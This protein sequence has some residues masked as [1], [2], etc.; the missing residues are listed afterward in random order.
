MLS[1]PASAADG[2]PLDESPNETAYFLSASLPEKDLVPLIQAA[3]KHNMPVYFRGLINNDMKTTANYIQYLVGKYHIAGI[4]ID[5]LRPGAGETL[6]GAVR[7]SVWQRCTQS[8]PGHHCAPRA[9]RRKQ[10]EA[11]MWR[12]TLS[13]YSAAGLLSLALNQCYAGD[14]NTSM[15]EGYSAAQTAGS[16]AQSSI[17]GAQPQQ[18]FEHYDANPPQSGYYQGGTQT[19]TSL[20]AKG[21]QELGTSEMGQ[22]ARESFINNP[23][24]KIDWDSDMMKNVRNIQ[25]NTRCNRRRHRAAAKSVE[26]DCRREAHIETRSKVVKK[27]KTVAVSV[28]MQSSWSGRWNGQLVIPEKARLL[29]VAVRA[30]GMPIPYSQACYYQW[31]GRRVTES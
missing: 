5:P 2:T 27:Q 12:A 11:P 8:G 22:L 3:E 6:W 21:Q 17:G 26:A 13:L 19:D 29:R 24:D 7:C 23:S 4:N 25:Q 28:P 31:N 18:Y 1:V 14:M 15:E 16:Q 20:G 9:V 10:P 30:S